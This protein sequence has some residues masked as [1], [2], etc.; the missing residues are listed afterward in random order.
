MVTVDY[1]CE[2]CGA[3]D[4]RSVPSPPP[5]TW[6]CA[7]CGSLA[8]RVYGGYSVP[9]RARRVANDRL[10]RERALRPPAHGISAHHHDHHHGAGEEQD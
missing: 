5:S 10:E 3:M 9:G 4:E 7:A 1:R 6:Q 2:G 8:R